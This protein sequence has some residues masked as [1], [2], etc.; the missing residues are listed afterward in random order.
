MDPQRSIYPQRVRKKSAGQFHGMY[1]E[2]GGVKWCEKAKN[3]EPPPATRASEKEEA[4][5]ACRRSE[6]SAAKSDCTKPARACGTHSEW[7]VPLE[8]L[9]AAG[10]LPRRLQEEMCLGEKIPI[11][12]WKLWQRITLV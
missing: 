3:K 5:G 10:W 8:H 12:T 11:G 4:S 9:Y 7:S 2:R 1:P 6:P